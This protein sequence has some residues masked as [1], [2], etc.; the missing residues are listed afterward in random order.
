MSPSLP[1]RAWRTYREEGLRGIWF[2]ALA[3]LGYR[4]L[5]LMRRPLCTPIPAST[6]SL[7]L[8]IAWLG[9]GDVEAYLAFRGGMRAEAVSARLDAGD[10]C[11]AAWH[12]G[13]IV[14]AM[15]GSTSGVRSLYLGRD[16]DLAPG[17]AFQFDVYT[18]P[19]AR[20]QGIAPSLTIAW[21]RYLRE[22]GYSAAIQLTLPE[23]RSALRAH[24]KV[25]YRVIGIVRSIQLGPWRAH[26]LSRPR[27]LSDSSV[28]RLRSRGC[29]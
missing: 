7:P 3:V 8:A 9:A 17:E 24:A 21:L 11:L 5:F 15:W 4:R 16:L 22:K 12:A 2:G 25:G 23:N 28:R 10:R 6:S 19:A 18:A 29:Q 27:M 14:G 20:G 1:L 26:A 13:C